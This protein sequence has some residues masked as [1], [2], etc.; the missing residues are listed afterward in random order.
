MVCWKEFPLMK[1]PFPSFVSLS[2][3]SSKVSSWLFCLRT[4]SFFCSM[5]S[6]LWRSSALFWLSLSC[7]SRFVHFYLSSARFSLSILTTDCSSSTTA[8]SFCICFILSKVPW[9][10][11][12]RSWYYSRPS[13]RP[14]INFCILSFWA[15]TDSSFMPFSLSAS[16]SSSS[17]S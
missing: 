1:L 3:S 14:V 13:W 12:L 17:L 9:C 7:S 11:I 6:C 10:S 15:V 2:F 8:T 16:N 4:S 5:V